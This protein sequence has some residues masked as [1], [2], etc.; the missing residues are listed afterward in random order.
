MNHLQKITMIIALFGL[1]GLA[2]ADNLPNLLSASPEEIEIT[3]S[4]NLDPVDDGS[5]DPSVTPDD[6]STPP[7]GSLDPIIE[8]GPNDDPVV[9]PEP[10]PAP[11]IHPILGQT[12]MAGTAC[13]NWDET[14]VLL[15]D[16]HMFVPVRTFVKRAQQEAF[17]RGSCQFAI[18]LRVPFG[19]R[20]VIKG[21]RLQHIANLPV[22]ASSKA[23]LEV[24]F[25]GGQGPKIQVFETAERGPRHVLNQPDVLTSLES[26]CGED[27]ILRGNSA[28]LLSGG[29]GSAT[30]KL[31]NL[32]LTYEVK[33]CEKP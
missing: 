24:F 8:P 31:D 4:P 28:I 20:L 2:L 13:A 15:T 25:A 17:K 23:D 3:A 5:L 22:E 11:V 21:I 16:H 30:A 9:T 7:Q 12:T 26:G 19:H 27:L 29:A 18:P 6:P 10:Q 33:S 32:V 1:A 14:P